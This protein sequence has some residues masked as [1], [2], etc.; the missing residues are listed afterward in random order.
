MLVSPEQQPSRVGRGLTEER[1]LIGSA[2]PI[3]FPLMRTQNN[4]R[5]AIFARDLGSSKKAAEAVILIKLHIGG[6]FAGENHVV[7]M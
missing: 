7:P 2:T 6:V 5:T 1:N 4:H 3:M